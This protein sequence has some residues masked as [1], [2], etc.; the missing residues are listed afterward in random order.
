MINHNYKD[1]NTINF[2]VSIDEC[3]NELRPHPK[4]K[5]CTFD[6]YH[7][8]KAYPSQAALKEIL[9]NISNTQKKKQKRSFFSKKQKENKIAKNIYID[10]T[11]GIGK[12]HLLAACFHNFKGSKAFM[13]F[14]ELTYFMN[15]SGLE[16]TI[17]FFKP[18]DLLLID[19]FDLDDPATTRM[20]ARFIESINNNTTIITTSNRLPKEL[21]GGKFDTTQFAR[22]LGIISNTFDTI[23]VEG[24]SFRINLA[25]WQAVYSN[26]SFNDVL[27]SY[28][29]KC[30]ILLVDF[31]DLIL[32][33]QENH[34]FKF[35]VIPKTFDAVFIKNFKPFT[36]LNDAL[37]FTI[38]IDHCYYHDT[39]LF[40]DGE[41]TEDIFPKEIME[42]SFERQFLRCNSRLD[43][44]G[45]FFKE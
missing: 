19:E 17:E 32:K 38:F 16:K 33:L 13:S 29:A 6:S 37:R 11:Y 8:D 44:L 23:T 15:F 26:K 2:N 4:F 3:F 25:S 34:P 31:Y 24:K 10:G 5:D 7:D 9:R 40:F 28:E 35:F 1:I 36:K 12:T 39:K 14:L 20:A 30:G 18:I 22:E 21:G 45:L 42:T 41:I 27:N 43:E